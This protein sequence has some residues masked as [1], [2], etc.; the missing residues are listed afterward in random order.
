MKNKSIK[1]LLLVPCC[2]LLLTCLLSL[3]PT[4][5]Q[6]L[7]PSVTI[8]SPIKGQEFN[9]GTVDLTLSVQNFVFVDFKNNTVPF[10]GNPNAGHAHMWI[11]PAPKGMES[12]VYEV[13]S[14]DIQNLDALDRGSYTVTVEL[15][16]NNHESFNPR[17]FETVSFKV[18]EPTTSGKY[19]V[20][21]RESVETVGEEPRKL[22]DL[23]VAVGFVAT[24]LIIFYFFG[25]LITKN[26][27]SIYIA[28]KFKTAYSKIIRKYRES[29][30]HKR[31]IQIGGHRFIKVVAKSLGL[32]FEFILFTINTLLLILKW[33]QKAINRLILNP[34]K[35]LYA[36]FRRKKED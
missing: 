10:P 21:S 36:K 35:K 27:Y 2:L 28:N 12:V 19:I 3:T 34:V 20:T 1:T 33:L 7:Q 22:T 17:V 23:L 9:G 13:K 6:T 32:A 31:L 5:A 24:L 26:K 18:N 16:Q 8:L 30:I 29:K 4:F 25:E 15:V 14:P 11:D